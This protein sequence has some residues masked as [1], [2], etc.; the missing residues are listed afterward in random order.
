MRAPPEFPSHDATGTDD[1]VP[2]TVHGF[3]LLVI[4]FLHVA[5]AVALARSA[6]SGTGSEPVA[7]RV[8][9]IAEVSSAPAAVASAPA[10]AAA[11]PS[12]ERATPLPRPRPPR[13]AANAARA[14]QP[15]VPSPE[16][17][18]PAVTPAVSTSAVS[19][20]SDMLAD[21][22]FEPPAAGRTEAPTGAASP[23]GLDLSAVAAM[24]RGT[25]GAASGGGGGEYIAPDFSAG[26]L[27]NPKPA[28]PALSR[29]LREQGLVR[30]RV[31]VT[32]EGR[33]NEIT[34]QESSGFD[35]LDKAALDAVKRW[36]FRPA[37]RSGTPVAGWVLV[38]LKFELEG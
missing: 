30:L 12:V 11:P 25:A 28:Y 23:A 4:V 36:Q 7:L 15:S 34:L 37:R 13:R 26:Y 8:N 19:T 27:S 33:A 35:R 20:T 21:P 1:S 3:L 6:P 2:W 9:W 10:P 24:S 22:A 38:P 16:R 14:P 31:H 18:V 17:V 29:R 32:E 5:G